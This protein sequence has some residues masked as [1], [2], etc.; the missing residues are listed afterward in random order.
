MVK[1]GN[2]GIKLRMCNALP[3]TGRGILDDGPGDNRASKSL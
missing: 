3:L 2:N 1:N